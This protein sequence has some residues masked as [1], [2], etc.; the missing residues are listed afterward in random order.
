MATELSNFLSDVSAGFQGTS[1][2]FNQ[3]GQAQHPTPMPMPSVQ[4]PY[5]TAAAVTLPTSVPPVG[6]SPAVAHM[7]QFSTPTPMMAAPY[8]HFQPHMASFVAGGDASGLPSASYMTAP[9]MGVYRTSPTPGHPSTV[10]S[11]VSRT[12]AFGDVMSMFGPNF[13]VGSGMRIRP[14]GYDPLETQA[15]HAT[16][17]INRA[18]SATATASAA[19]L[20]FAGARA[21]DFVGSAV[22]TYFGGIA[23]GFAGSWVGEAAGMAAGYHLNPLQ[24]VVKR[25]EDALKLRSISRGVVTTGADL[26]VTG[27]GMTNAASSRLSTGLYNAAADSSLF[28]REDYIKISKMAAENGM[29]NM[30]NTP[31][32]ILRTV[33]DVSKSLKVFMSVA[34][35][36]DVQSAISRMGDLYRMGISIPR[37]TEA[38]ANIRQFARMAGVSVD[39]AM[40]TYGA[41]G[42]FL[43]KNVGLTQGAGVQMGVAGAGIGNALVQ[44][45]TLSQADVN[46]L[47][48]VA[49]IGQNITQAAAGFLGGGANAILPGLMSIGPDGRPQIDQ[50][51]LQAYMSGKTSYGEL[52]PQLGVFGGPNGTQNLQYFLNNSGRIQNQLAETLGPQ[53]TVTFMMRAV[54]DLQR[55]MPGAT[56]QTVAKML[57][58]DDNTALVMSELAN[59][60]TALQSM[61]REA[62]REQR[63]VG[64][65]EY[66]RWLEENTAV[67]RNIARPVR[68]GLTSAGN[69]AFGGIQG[70]WAEWDDVSR[71][72]AA[73]LHRRTNAAAGLAIRGDAGAGGPGRTYNER[74]HWYSPTRPATQAL[75]RARGYEGISAGYIGAHLSLFGGGIDEE[76]AASLRG[77]DEL[78]SRD[79]DAV[80]YTALNRELQGAMG[81]DATRLLEMFRSGAGAKGRDLAAYT[82]EMLQ[83]A[84]NKRYSADIDI[85]TAR[86]A[87]QLGADM[88]RGDESVRAAL[89][90]TRYTAAQLRPLGKSGMSEKAILGGIQEDISK[91]L[92]FGVG[93]ASAKN[94]LAIS[95]F[96]GKAGVAGRADEYK[97]LTLLGDAISGKGQTARSLE[98]RRALYNIEGGREALAAAESSPEISEAFS[99]LYWK[100][101]AKRG[102][103]YGIGDIVGA[104]GNTTNIASWSLLAD[105]LEEQNIDIGDLRSNFSAKGLRS[106]GELSSQFKGKS[107]KYVLDWASNVI[108]GR[109]A[110]DYVGGGQGVDEMRQAT[111]T[112]LMAFSAS[113]DKSSI[114]ME[115]AAEKFERAANMLV[116]AAERIGE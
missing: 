67:Q 46:R 18:V 25:R 44:G 5:G 34:G 14:L 16:S 9:S 15:A 114:R 95:K 27:I 116:E 111:N 4:T 89:E 48:G 3:T 90:T 81:E 20:T 38:Q 49:G 103:K 30:S 11:Q 110:V 50:N 72:E 88:Y 29:I 47:G 62:N 13:G 53:G 61:M 94:V 86:K 22:G 97:I 84:Y 54:E 77:A 73:G 8:P 57:T 23:G 24:A 7:Q 92:G 39:E 98:A 52:I 12:G 115:N 65:V 112:A 101:S 74:A 56:V 35:D 68:R 28:N 17:M 108:S 85:G 55:T 71:A 113:A 69:A 32:Q 33:K 79:I 87:Y 102:S 63:R 64:S 109:D 75:L 107:D 19:A 37:M 1:A 76:F 106:I 70:A 60:P 104:A 2:A 40:S 83:Q 99:S 36:P 66:T 58:D 10:G 82:P 45:G 51:K 6:M 41:Q 105:T 96:A 78:L 31:D 26:D 43:Y 42:G 91:T 93:G 59:N 100:T 80:G 21:G